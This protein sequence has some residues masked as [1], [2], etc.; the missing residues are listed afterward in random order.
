M[1]LFEMPH[2]TSPSSTATFRCWSRF[3]NVP[4]FR[5]N[6]KDKRPKS[7]LMAPAQ[8]IFAI[9]FTYNGTCTCQLHSNNFRSGHFASMRFTQYS[10]AL[11]QDVTNLVIGRV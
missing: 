6:I 11:I 10:K 8:Q 2:T 5:N 1:C 3:K 9:K 4:I 7:F